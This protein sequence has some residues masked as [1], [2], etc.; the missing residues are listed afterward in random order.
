MIENGVSIEELQGSS[1]VLPFENTLSI[2][3]M[4]STTN[5]ILKTGEYKKNNTSIKKADMDIRY[6]T[7]QAQRNSA[8]EKLSLNSFKLEYDKS[9]DDFGI[10]L[11]VR[12]PLTRNTYE[13]LQEKQALHYTSLEAQ[14]IRLEIAEQLREKQNQLRLLSHQWQSMIKVE[15]KI[16]ARIMR[17]SN[18]TNLELLFDL[19]GHLLEVQKRKERSQTQALREYI[20]FLSTAE[21]LSVKPYRNW[22]LEGAPRLF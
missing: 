21:M 10:S 16:N 7:A 12:M 9:D 8:K 18:S 6:A 17:L 13:K 14:N 2:Q 20:R 15:N 19:K 3:R 4:L 1:G 5:R 11:G 22:L